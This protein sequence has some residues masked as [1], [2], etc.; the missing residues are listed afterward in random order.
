MDLHEIDRTHVQLLEGF[1]HALADAGRL[2]DG[3]LGCDED[4]V[5]NALETPAHDRFAFAVDTAV[6]KNRSPLS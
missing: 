5:A 3:N 1:L 2:R 6:S 4:L